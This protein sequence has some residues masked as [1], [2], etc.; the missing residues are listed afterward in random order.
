VVIF[1]MLGLLHLLDSIPLF[2][3][4][5]VIFCSIAGFFFIRKTRFHLSDLFSGLSTQIKKLHVIDFILLGIMALVLGGFF[6]VGVST[7]PNNTDS[8]AVHLPRIY[9]WLQHGSFENWPATNLAQLFYPINGNIQG[10]WLFLLSGKETLFFLVQWS[11]LGVILVSTYAIARTLKFNITSSLVSALVIL[12]FPV[13]LL[14]TYS[15]QGDLTIAALVMLSIYLVFSY[16]ATKKKFELIGAMIVFALALGTK[17]TAFFILPIFAG[18]IIYLLFAKQIPKTDWAYLGLF[19]LFF[20]IFASYRYFQNLQTDGTIFGVKNVLGSQ[21]L[22]LSDIFLKVQYNLPRYFYQ[23]IS[24]DGVFKPVAEQLIAVK[25]SVFE[26]LSSLLRIDL[27]APLFLSPGASFKYLGVPSLTEDTS[28]F[29]PLCF[30]MLPLGIIA[31]LFRKEKRINQYLVFALLAGFEYFFFI[32]FQRSG[33]TPN[34]G[35]YFLLGIL[36]LVPLFSSLI[37]QRRRVSVF[38]SLIVTFFVIILAGTILV[39]NDSKPLV[40]FRSAINFQNQVNARI[41]Q[42][43]LIHTIENKILNHSIIFIADCSP[44]RQ[45]FLGADYYHQL[46]F[47]HAT[48]IKNIDFFN[49]YIP[50]KV[51]VSIQIT[52]SIDEYAFFGKNKTRNLYPVNNVSE[53]EPGSFFL[54]RNDQVSNELTQLTKLGSNNLYSIYFVK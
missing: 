3:L 31:T 27:Q 26:K 40:T 34:Q 10:M 30:I 51:P 45:L 54:I 11:S 29:G 21:S 36:P 15:F 19:P 52:S 8:L 7:P 22:V 50:P 13:A 25:A 43:T 44:Y 20:L 53:V 16:L 38:T 1:E 42:D 2:F 46:Y 32:L 4:L 37:P 49:S 9:Y 35:R 48:Q 39:F 6:A 12:S 18:F 24:F 14:Q 23:F 41:P 33:W 5:Q 28:W 17:Q 47:S